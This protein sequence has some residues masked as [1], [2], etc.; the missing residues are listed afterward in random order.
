MDWMSRFET[1]RK[2]EHGNPSQGFGFIAPNDP[3]HQ[4]PP[5]PIEQNA[6]KEKE[7]QLKTGDGKMDLIPYSKARSATFPPP[8]TPQTCVF[9]YLKY[10][11][12]F[13][14]TQPLLV[15]LAAAEKGKEKKTRDFFIP[16]YSTVSVLVEG[17]RAPL[18]TPVWKPLL[19]RL[20]TVLRYL[21]RPVP[22]VFLL[23]AFSDQWSIHSQSAGGGAAVRHL[24]GR[25]TLP[26]LRSGVSTARAS[27]L[28]DVERAATTTTAHGV[29]FVL[30]P[31]SSTSCPSN[32]RLL[33]NSINLR[34]GVGGLT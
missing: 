21:M 8:P 25:R 31:L 12:Y 9:F 17:P 14:F 18:G 30:Y 24:E 2:V 22:V 10:S 34:G 19:N 33:S 4:T 29:R 5:R 26:G 28:L 7:I 6:R 32:T 3:Y 20:L 11:V 27:V 23:M 16:I 15:L 13:V 1:V